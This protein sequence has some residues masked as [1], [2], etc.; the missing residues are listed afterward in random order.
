MFN[1][2]TIIFLADLISLLAYLLVDLRIIIKNKTICP[3]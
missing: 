1:S 2:R 3:Y